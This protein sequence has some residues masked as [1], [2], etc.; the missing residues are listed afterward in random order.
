MPSVR[1]A[2]LT[3]AGVGRPG[4]CATS[5]TI[6]DEFAARYLPLLAATRLLP[7]PGTMDPVRDQSRNPTTLIGERA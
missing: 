5:K 3:T 2:Y 7:G 1:W 4:A 6:V